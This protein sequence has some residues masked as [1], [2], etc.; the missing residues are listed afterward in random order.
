DCVDVGVAQVNAMREDAAGSHEPRLAYPLDG[1][2]A[3]SLAADAVIAGVFGDVNVGASAE[4]GAPAVNALQRHVI[5]GERRMSAAQCGELAIG[6]L[7]R[8]DDI[9]AT[10]LQTGLSASFPVTVGDFVA[11]HAAKAD[12]GDAALDGIERAGDGARR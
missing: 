4:F 9:A 5:A 8:F 12:R 6:A 1:A 7:L 11:K 10:F 2:F 3:V